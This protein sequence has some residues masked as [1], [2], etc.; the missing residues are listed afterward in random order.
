MAKRRSSSGRWLQEHFS[1][2]F[3]KEAKVAG[4]RSRA[5][6]KLIEIQERDR[7]FKPGMMIVDLG[8]APGGWSQI[9]TRYIKPR[10]R[11]IAIDILPMEA[12]PSVEFMQGDF[13]EEN[14][15]TDLLS[16]LGVTEEKHPV[17]WVI[18]DMAP[19]M[20]GNESVD[21]PRSM[22]LAE[23][24]LEFALQ[25]LHQEG[26]LLIK[27]FQGE[28]FDQ[29][30]L[31]IKQSFKQVSIRKPKASRSRSREVYVVAS[32]RKVK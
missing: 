19:N 31:D 13:T 32:M 10:G 29:L 18:S 2:P 17:D 12:L 23:L 6:F 26:G 15:V 5:A 11:V 21:I 14:F 16:F 3:V 4:Y 30:I 8:A 25:V 20:S 24:A 22:Y 28:G 27:V 9:V 7:I 1:D